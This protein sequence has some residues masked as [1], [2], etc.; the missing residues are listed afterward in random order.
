ME[1]EDIFLA[2]GCVVGWIHM[3][4]SHYGTSRPIFL[5]NEALTLTGAFVVMIQKMIFSDILRFASIYVVLLL[6]KENFTCLCI[7]YAQAL[8]KL[9]L[10][11]FESPMFMDSVLYLA[12]ELREFFVKNA[13]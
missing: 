12:G 10:C 7:Y 11:C 13:A 6:G 3:L 2:I 9:S 4:T 1:A 5:I 8:P